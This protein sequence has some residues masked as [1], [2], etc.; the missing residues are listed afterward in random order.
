MNNYEWKRLLICVIEII[1]F[2]EFQKYVHAELAWSNPSK[3]VIL[4]VDHQVANLAYKYV[5]PNSVIVS[6]LTNKE[7]IDILGRLGS[8]YIWRFREGS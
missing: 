2:D 3:V 8:N 7:Y 4:L 6:A 1:V 5:C